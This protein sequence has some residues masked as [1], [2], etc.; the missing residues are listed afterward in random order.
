MHHSVI[1]RRGRGQVLCFVPLTHY[2][3]TLYTRTPQPQLGSARVPSVCCTNC[4]TTTTTT[5]TAAAPPLS[6]F[7]QQQRNN[8]QPTTF[9]QQS[10]L[11]TSKTRIRAYSTS[12]PRCVSQQ[13]A[14]LPAMAEYDGKWTAAT[15]RKTFLDYF[16]EQ[17]HTIGTPAS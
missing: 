2:S 10:L 5:T 1:G 16:A 13:Q 6:L 17:G 11:S 8:G 12:L 7:L 3:R 4:P 15:V 14:I 9:R